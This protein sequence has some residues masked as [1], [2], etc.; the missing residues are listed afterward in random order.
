MSEIAVEVESLS[1][2]FKLY[3]SQGKRLLDYVTFGKKKF[4]Q[5]FWALKN[6]SFTVPKG[7][8]F[9][10]LGQN[11]SGK[12]TLLSILAGVLDPTEGNFSVHGK[13]SAIL[14]LGA[15]F[16]PEF[17]GRANA[18][19]YGSIM[20]LSKEI[21]DERI[22][23][24]VHFSELG[25][26]ID[27]P[28]RTYSSGMYARL[29]FSVAVNVNA[30]ILIIDEALSVG[31]ALFQHRCFRKIHELKES[32]KTIL[33]V[34]HDTEAVRSLCDHAM[35]L[36]GGCMLDIGESAQISNKYMAMIAE[37]EQKYYE[38]NLQEYGEKPD[39]QWRGIFNFIDHLNEAEKKIQRPDNIRELRIDIR[40]AP[41]RTI[42]AHPPSELK[43]LVLIEKGSVL[44]FAIGI[45]PSAYDFISDGVKFSVLIDDKKIF[46]R[47]LQPKTNMPDRGWHN[48]IIDLAE[49][50]GREISIRFITEGI[51]Q[52]ISYCWGG[53]GWMN[54][55]QKI[56][57]QNTSLSINSWEKDTV[58]ICQVID[59]AK[60]IRIGSKKAE[61]YKIEL[62][63]SSFLPSNTFFSG[64]IAFVRSHIVCHEDADDKLTAGCVIKNKYGEVWGTNTS[65]EGIQI[66]P[67]RKGE[68]FIIQFEVPL[69]F[70]EG[71][72]SITC[73]CGLVVRQNQLLELFD[74]HIEAILF[75]VKSEKKFV[76]SLALSSKI[77]VEFV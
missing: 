27:Q 57:K 3:P 52:D 54:I 42:F 1:K 24:I 55:S 51:G 11:G 64:D 69:L 62:L 66:G 70:T 75:T 56:E 15:G 29:A 8:T 32:G 63:N 46:S 58:P 22:P 12:S 17:T 77:T 5:E 73:G 23:D 37:R 16:H 28:L 60:I 31:D 48:Q 21:M 47:I 50:C 65:V 7:S 71:I 26:F 2:M 40:N 76:G 38:A 45:Y 74:R 34:G 68:K 13:V 44:S 61:I 43:Y 9:G 67:K 18:Y 59:E 10:I 30:D 6:I 36:D 41:R 53:W 39:E 49:Y 35:I 20:G 72:Y 4:Y 14:E 19:M 33:Y 25:D